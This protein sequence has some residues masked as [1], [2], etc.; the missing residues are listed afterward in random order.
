M[1]EARR[2]DGMIKQ[3]RQELR[4][5][6]EKDTVALTYNEISTEEEEGM[7]REKF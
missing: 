2:E 1:E 3:R 6:K 5:K 4:Q 7:N